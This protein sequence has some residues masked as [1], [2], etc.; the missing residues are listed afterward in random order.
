MGMLT[1][2]DVDPLDLLGEIQAKL[3]GRRTYQIRRHD[4]GFRASLRTRYNIEPDDH[5]TKTILALHECQTDTMIATGHPNYFASRYTQEIPE[6]P[7]F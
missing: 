3:A 7:A 1:T 6:R 5:N 4:E 2:L